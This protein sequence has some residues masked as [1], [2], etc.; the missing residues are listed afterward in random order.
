MATH[1]SI[2]AWKSHG[3]RTLVGYKESDT[4]QRRSME[5]R[6]YIQ[7]SFLKLLHSVIFPWLKL[8]LVLF[9]IRL[10]NGD[11]KDLYY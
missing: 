7:C 10:L 11:R 8:H 2:L 3:Q 1:S 9:Y 4:T 6:S 5:M